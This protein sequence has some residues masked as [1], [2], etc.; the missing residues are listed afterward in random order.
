SPARAWHS[1]TMLPDG[2]VLILGGIGSNRQ[3]VAEPQI[4]DLEGGTVQR[5]SIPEMTPR[6]H[7]TPTVLTTGR[8]LVAG[9]DDASGNASAAAEVWT[10]ET[11]ALDTVTMSV[12][13]SGHTATL[14]SDGR[15]L[16]W[17]GT[18]ALIDSGE[19]FD[20]ETA[21]F[22]HITAIPSESHTFDPPRLEASVPLTGTAD[23]PIDGAITLRFSKPLRIDSLSEAPVTLPGPQG[24]EPLR[25]VAAEGGMLAF[26]TP[27]SPIIPSSRYS[28]VLNGPED[29]EGYLLPFTQVEFMTA[30]PTASSAATRPGSRSDGPKGHAHHA[31]RSVKPGTRS[32]TDDL[33]WAGP[34]R[35]GKPYSR[36]QDLPPLSAPPG[37]TA[38]AG[39]VLRLNGQPLADVT[40]RIGVQAAVTDRTG[41]FLL[42]GLTEGRQELIMDGSTANQPGRTYGTF[43]YGVDITNK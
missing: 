10:Q 33:E 34:R 38:L 17:A 14:L 19:I 18:G 12:G 8:V 36:W 2:T 11:G 21:T 24:P 15:V 23:V 28:L 5:L 6:A 7:P 39:Q 20:P 4:L 32:E 41:R 30:W 25:V 40:L 43:D 31:A 27:S 37:V 13:R 26:V 3:P 1:A 29:R 22:S 9:G 42:A 35:D 16:L